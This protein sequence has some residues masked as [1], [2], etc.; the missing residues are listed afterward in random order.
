MLGSPSPRRSRPRLRVLVGVAATGALLS[1]ALA[2]LAPTASSA[3]QASATTRATTPPNTQVNPNNLPLHDGTQK[4]GVFNPTSYGDIPRQSPEVMV[5][6]PGNGRLV[7]LNQDIQIQ[8]SFRNFE[9]GFFNDAATQYGIGA[10]SINADGNLQGHNHGCLQRLP[11]DGTAPQVKCDS[12]VVLDE[13]ATPG[14]LVGVA[15]P[16][17]QPGRYRL[18]VDAAAG[19]HYPAARAFARDGGPVDCIR[20]LAVNRRAPRR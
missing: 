18:C 13:G 9:P 4:G 1:A 6:R 8:A 15:P 3:Q 7:A 5:T 17:T 14:T 11:D 12:F 10:Q 16:L 20:I 19:N 2:A